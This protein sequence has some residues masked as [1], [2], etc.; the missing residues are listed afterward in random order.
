[1]YD[2]RLALFLHGGGGG[3]GAWGFC[4]VPWLFLRLRSSEP[5]SLR[6][7]LQ[8]A[9]TDALTLFSLS[10]L[11]IYFF[12]YSCSFL[13]Q[14][15]GI[16][17][18]CPTAFFSTLLNR[19]CP[20]YQSGPL[21]SNSIFVFF[22]TLCGDSHFDCSNSSLYSAQTF[23]FTIPATWLWRYMFALSTW[24]LHPAVMS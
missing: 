11:G 9:T 3:L 4:I 2:T 10:A 15:L 12:S 24:I 19:Q 1:M 20:V 5:R 17:K 21:K 22:A 6:F 14:S 13:L 7:L 18:S 8:W 23:L 16:S